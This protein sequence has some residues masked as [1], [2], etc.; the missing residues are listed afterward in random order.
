MFFFA[1]HTGNAGWGIAWFI[2]GTLIPELV[3]Q[4]NQ[5]YTFVIFG[6]DDDSPE[7]AANYHPFYITDSPSGGRLLNDANER[8]V[9]PVHNYNVLPLC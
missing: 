4:R 5:T 9:R 6:G 2:D 3:V 7:E 8:M 1:Q